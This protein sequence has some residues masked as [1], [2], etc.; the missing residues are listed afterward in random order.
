MVC[1]CVYSFIPPVSLEEIVRR[2]AEQA[3]TRLYEAVDHTMALE[4][5]SNDQLG[6][7]E[8]IG[9]LTDEL[10]RT[11]SRELW[12]KADADKIRISGRGDAA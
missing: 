7:R 4:G 10:I 9:E 5:Q 8:Q 1:A 11:L 3:A 12:E 6:R 2:Q